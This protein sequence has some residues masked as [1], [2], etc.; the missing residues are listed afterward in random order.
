MSLVLL[1]L[2]VFAVSP[3][4]AQSNGPFTTALSAHAISPNSTLN[5]IVVDEQNAVVPSAVVLVTDVKGRFKRQLETDR[6]GRFAVQLLAPAN[7]TVSVQ[8]LGFARAEIKDVILRVNDR[9]VLKIQLRIGSVD[10][11]VMV[12]THTGSLRQSP[13]LATN[14]DP[15]F[16]EN[17]PLTG[18]T[19]Q[20]LISLIPGVFPSDNSSSLHTC[21]SLMVVARRDRLSRRRPRRSHSADTSTSRLQAIRVRS[22]RW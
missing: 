13:E 14:I 8:H 7:Y 12:D 18:R 10:G 22:A 15:T 5:G 19:L 17:L 3:H 16:V 4:Y 6:D 1:C 20:P 21:S 11:R 2:L 9:L